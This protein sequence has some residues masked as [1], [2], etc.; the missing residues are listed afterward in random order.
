LKFE[1]FIFTQYSSKLNGEL[2]AGKEKQLVLFSDIQAMRLSDAE[3]DYLYFGYESFDLSF[4]KVRN[5]IEVQIVV[6]KIGHLLNDISQF[7]FISLWK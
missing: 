4:M 1:S 6:S 3:L 2:Y 5:P 7:K